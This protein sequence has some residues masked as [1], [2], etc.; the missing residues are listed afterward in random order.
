M[1]IFVS[2]LYNRCVIYL[3]LK[4]KQ[5]EDTWKDTSYPR[6]LMTL[7]HGPMIQVICWPMYFCRGY[8]FHT[9]DH[10]K[11]KKNA[12]YGVCVK[13]T[14]SCGSSEEPD[15]YGVLREIYELR[16]PGLVDLKVVVFKCDWYDS[17]IGKGIRINKSGIIDINSGGCYGKYD[18]F[19]LASQADQVCYIPYPRKTQ[20]KK[21]QDWKAAIMVPPRGKVFVNKKLD[22]TAMQH[23]NDASIVHADSLHVEILTDLNSLAEELDDIEEVEFGSDAEKGNPDI[24]LTDE[25]ESE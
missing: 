7:V 24:E 17:T 16:Y 2:L 11:D 3:D 6:W 12:N 10:G 18:P 25:E 20:P 13:D 1:V 19:I 5:V 15:F 23:E 21:D 14:T 8:V 9:Y 4:K 22:F